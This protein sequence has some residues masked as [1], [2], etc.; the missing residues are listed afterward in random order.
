[1]AERYVRIYRRRE[2]IPLGEF[3]SIHQA[4]AFLNKSHK[5]SL[6]ADGGEK[7]KE[8]AESLDPVVAGLME[9]GFRR[10]MAE[11]VA[12]K[13]TVSAPGEALAKTTIFRKEASEPESE[14]K[15]EPEPEPPPLVSESA[16]APGI[17]KR[18]EIAAEWFA[19]LSYV[20]GSYRDWRSKPGRNSFVES[21][22]R[23]GKR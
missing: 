18:P 23:S 17:S 10:E 14:P 7:S 15:P 12:A 11:I 2:E 16:P 5:L 8:A 21:S 13:A 6:P 19:E 1:M 22:G 4:L 20:M 9:K 3:R